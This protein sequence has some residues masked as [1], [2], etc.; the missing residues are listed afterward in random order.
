MWAASVKC[1][2]LFGC[3]RESNT[4]ARSGRTS[5]R[6]ACAS[7]VGSRQV[8]VRAEIKQVLDDDACRVR[9]L[10]RELL[11]FTSSSAMGGN[12]VRRALRA[13]QSCYLRIVR[14]PDATDMKDVTVIDQ[15][16]HSRHGATGKPRS[17][18]LPP[19]STV[20]VREPGCFQE[21]GVSGA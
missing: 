1:S 3:K 16:P 7:D 10:R 19:S 21:A 20:A 12:D 14:C 2:M 6:E 11:Q 5:L 9:K 17:A 15:F 8:L 4:T 13:N 18:N